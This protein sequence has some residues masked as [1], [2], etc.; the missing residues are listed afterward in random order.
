MT[1]DYAMSLPNCKQRPFCVSHIICSGI[2]AVK[3]IALSFAKEQDG[4]GLRKVLLL[5]S[6]LEVNV[7]SEAAL[8]FYKDFTKELMC[9]GSLI[10][11][12]RQKTGVLSFISLSFVAQRQKAT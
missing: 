7:L 10:C 5:S 9:V 4:E 6:S 8:H 2:W 12:V 1:F 11:S 3:C